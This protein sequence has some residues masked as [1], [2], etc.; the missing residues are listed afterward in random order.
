MITVYYKPSKTNIYQPSEVSYNAWPESVV[1]LGVKTQCEH[2]MYQIPPPEKI[3]EF[4]TFNPDSK[5]ILKNKNKNKKQTNKAKSDSN[6]VCQLKGP[7]VSVQCT[8]TSPQEK[9]PVT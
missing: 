4:H 2:A 7:N 5:S 9:E 6:S 8:K 3:P 1:I